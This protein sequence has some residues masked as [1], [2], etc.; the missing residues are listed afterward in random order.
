MSTL[1]TA[2]IHGHLKCS[3]GCTTSTK[4]PLRNSTPRWV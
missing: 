4:A 2:S 3:P 1:L